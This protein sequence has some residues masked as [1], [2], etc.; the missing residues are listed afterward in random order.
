MIKSEV[1]NLDVQN[2]AVTSEQIETLRTH[3]QNGSGSLALKS[4]QPSVSD[5]EITNLHKK[6]QETDLDLSELFNSDSPS[7]ESD[8]N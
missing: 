1:I 3:L 2:G 8:K 6:L 7:D 4:N 5:E